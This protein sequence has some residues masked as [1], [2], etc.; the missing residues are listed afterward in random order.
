MLDKTELEQQAFQKGYEKA[1]NEFY[2]T[3]SAKMETIQN[4]N[5]MLVL[6]QALKIK[7]LTELNQS[8][9]ATNHL[10]LVHKEEEI[11]RLV[12]ELNQKELTFEQLTNTNKNTEVSEALAR[13]AVLDSTAERLRNELDA[14][15]RKY[16][17]F[18][19]LHQQI[20]ELYNNKVEEIELLQGQIMELKSSEE[21]AKSQNELAEALDKVKVLDTTV[22]TLR[23]DLD[24]LQKKH[25]ALKV[26]AQ[27]L[28]NKNKKKE[29]PEV[30]ASGADLEKLRNDLLE[31]ERSFKEQLEGERSQIEKLQSDFAEN[32]RLF[33]EQLEKERFEVNKLQSEYFQGLNQK[34]SEQLAQFEKNFTRVQE[35]NDLLNSELDAVREHLKSLESSHKSSHTQMIGNMSIDHLKEATINITAPDVDAGQG[36]LNEEFSHVCAQLNDRINEIGMLNAEIDQLKN[37]KSI[38][39]KVLSQN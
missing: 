21:L 1:S 37:G 33:K 26:K 17:E 22:E 3:V 11:K 25:D 27:T 30:T 16:A 34:F 23:S 36:E 14:L 8:L 24:A 35:E 13:N 10:E 28:K 19:M 39:Y 18:E 2:N 32:E 7:D 15:Q 20:A 6:D 29:D 5:L 4:E 9:I 12:D 31:S 38:E